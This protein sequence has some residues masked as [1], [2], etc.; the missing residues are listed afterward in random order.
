MA[1]GPP[2]APSSETRD[3]DGDRRRRRRRHFH[4]AFVSRTFA[5]VSVPFFLRPFSVRFGCFRPGRSLV[6]KKAAAAEAAHSYRTES[7]ETR[8]LIAFSR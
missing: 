1:D 2:M 5:F 3:I 8:T 7:K 6:S 4:P